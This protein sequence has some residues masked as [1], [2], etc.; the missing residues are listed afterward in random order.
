MSTP[1][2]PTPDPAR[3]T[4]RVRR[5]GWCALFVYA[6]L[7]MGLEAAHGFKLSA[8][9]DDPL[10]RL[11]LRLAH[12]HGVGL[13]LL[14]LVFGSAGLPLLRNDADAGRGVGTLLQSA[15]ILL[16]LG[17][18]LGAIAHPEGDPGPAVLLAPIG[19]L[20]LLL[21]LGRTAL[22]ALREK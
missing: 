14:L 6:A 1:S 20:C 5:F 8:Y 16:P 17:F 13:S 15:T 18:G 3:E 19:A 12:A 11:L 2:A 7:G 10:T 21:G 22:A 9:L 4:R